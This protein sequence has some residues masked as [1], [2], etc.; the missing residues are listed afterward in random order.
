MLRNAAALEQMQ[1]QVTMGTGT[2][3][4]RCANGLVCRIEKNSRGSWP[5]SISWCATFPLA[6]AALDM[7]IGS[8]PDHGLLFAAG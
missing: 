2:H 5:R 6:E 8:H 3:S 4:P 7:A 1:T